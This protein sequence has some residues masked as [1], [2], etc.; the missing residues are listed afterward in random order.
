MTQETGLSTDQKESEETDQPIEPP[1]MRECDLVMKGGITSGIVYPPLVLKL[2]DK[3]RFR[4]VGGTSAGAIAA[5]ATAAAEFGREAGGFEKLA[6]LNEELGT[7]NF[8]RDLFQPSQETR[9]LMETAF[10]I[11]GLKKA[12]LPE[13]K[14]QARP[15]NFGRLREIFTFL[16][17]NLSRPDLPYDK[18]SRI[19]FFAA[20]GIALFISFIAL[21]VLLL[22]S[23][24]TGEASFWWLSFVPLLALLGP[25]VTLGGKAGGIVYSARALY[26]ILTK[27]VTANKFGFCTG[28]K[29]QKMPQDAEVLTNWLHDRIDEMAGI[30]ER[31]MDGHKDVHKPLTF[32]DLKNKKFGDK[33]DDAS[34]KEENISLR[35]VTSNLSQN[36]PFVLPFKNDHLLL[37]NEEEFRL[38]FP[39]D[40]VDY[41][42]TL[43]GSYHAGAKPESKYVRHIPPDKFHFLPE[44]DDLPVIVATRMSLSFPLLLSAIPLH[45]IKSTSWVRDKKQLEEADL[46]RNWFSDGGICSNFPIHFFDSWLP[47]RPTFGVNLTSLPKEAMKESKD[48]VKRE[49]MSVTTCQDENISKNMTEAIYL[50]KPKDVLATEWV[51]FAD[52]AAGEKLNLF[53]FLWA[54]F[55]TAQNYRDNSQS[56]L[57]SYR[58]RIV[59]IRLSE[60]E[61]GLNLA[62]PTGTISDVMKKGDYAG[63][64]LLGFDFKVHQWVRFRVLMKQ[65]EASLRK[66]KEVMSGDA[67]KF[68]SVSLFERQD[69]DDYPY[70]CSIPWP[71]KALERLIIMNKLMNEWKEPVDLFS[72]EPSPYPEPVLRVMP[73]I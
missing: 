66:M 43:S 63:E 32:G 54:I 59:Q 46:Q 13:D 69:K 28:L 35:M 73:E 37:F 30:K 1:R 44:A 50:P 33:R 49:N 52:D 16:D 45:T 65:I 29:D 25:L 24:L 11:M 20:F 39:S 62:M 36:Q 55:S 53:K 22:R 68:D 3:Y 42:V 51:S 27:K 4:S 19:G 58:E 34:P 12:R 56:M 61:G 57:P 72:Q 48:Q 38:L 67:P 10:A 31:K 14:D 2:K 6:A 47:T 17:E 64:L 23:M 40:V 15:R 8:L 70:K 71:E 41:M 7:P 5:A 26:D 60:D 18:G 21:F 9:P